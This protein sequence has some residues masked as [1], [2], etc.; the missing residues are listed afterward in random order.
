MGARL[1]GLLCAEAGDTAKARELLADA[2]ARATRVSDAYQWVHAHALDSA[3]ALA[4]RTGAADAPE[5]VDILAELAAR[6]GLR[7]LVV[8]AHV[9]RSRLGVSGALGSARVLASEIDNPML[10]LLVSRDVSG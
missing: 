5:I 10:E 9:H 7:E 8:R 1:L 6:C 2:V 4:V 3:A